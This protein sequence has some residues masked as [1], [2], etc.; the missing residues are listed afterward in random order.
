V[1]PPFLALHPIP[2]PLPLSPHFPPLPD[3]GVRRGRRS[4]AALDA[5]GLKVGFGAYSPGIVCIPISI[6]VG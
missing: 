3:G 6:A 2:L 4:R 5:A 1:S